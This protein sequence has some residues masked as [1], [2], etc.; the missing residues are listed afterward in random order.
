MLLRRSHLAKGDAFALLGEGGK[1]LRRHEMPV[2]ALVIGEGEGAARALIRRE[3]TE[4]RLGG[5]HHDVRGLKSLVRGGEKG[6]RAENQQ[7]ANPCFTK[8]AHGVSFS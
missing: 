7:T 1:G 4:I 2:H 8:L 5:V 6:C 3:R